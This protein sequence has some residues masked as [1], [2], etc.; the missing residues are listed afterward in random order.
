VPEFWRYNGN[1]LQIYR[2]E[3]GQYLKCDTSP[4]F[5]PVLVTEI[6]DLLKKAE[7]W[8]NWHYP[9]L[10][11]LGLD[12]NYNALKVIQ[13]CCGTSTNSPDLKRLISTQSAVFLRFPQKN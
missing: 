13:N 7:R 8:E 6:P 10:L 2:L 12:S 3:S 5:D 4:T 1:A 9:V 11:E